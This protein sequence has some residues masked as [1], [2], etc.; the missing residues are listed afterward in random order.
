[1]QEHVLT[2]SIWNHLKATTSYKTACQHGSKLKEAVKH[3][4]V[5]TLAHGLTQSM[6]KGRRNL[7]VLDFPKVSDKVPHQHVLTNFDFMVS[8]E[9]IMDG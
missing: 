5:V 7:I 3:N 2:N 6:D 9:Q 4:Y 8:E 1:M